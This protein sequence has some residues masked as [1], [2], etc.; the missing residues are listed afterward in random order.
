MWVLVASDDKTTAD[1]LLVS[2]GILIKPNEN[3]KKRMIII[4]STDSIS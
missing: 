2:R 4:H 3:N 1:V